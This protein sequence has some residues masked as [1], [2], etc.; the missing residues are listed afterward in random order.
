MP[1]PGLRRYGKRIVEVIVTAV[2]SL[3]VY[4]RRSYPLNFWKSNK[5]PRFFSKKSYS[6][7][8]A[9][10]SDSE[11]GVVHYWC[12]DRTDHRSLAE[13]SEGRSAPYEARDR[14]QPA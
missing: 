7:P 5:L 14:G 10:P 2:E 6:T 1:L 13:R 4:T 12:D 9:Y 11:R 8:L 3:R